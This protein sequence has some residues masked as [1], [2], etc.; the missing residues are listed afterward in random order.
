MRQRQP[1]RSKLQQTRSLRVDHATRDV[2]VRDRVPVEKQIVVL[3]VVEE[4][5][6]GY[7]GGD[8]CDSRQ[9]AIG[10]GRGFWDRVTFYDHSPLCHGLRI[11][12]YGPNR[13]VSTRGRYESARRFPRA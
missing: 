3:K 4:R 1:H 6:Q 9:I 12:R 5:E 7:K 11:N 10:N 2:E 13:D 8:P